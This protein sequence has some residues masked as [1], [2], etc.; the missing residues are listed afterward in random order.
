MTP[1]EEK[2]KLIASMKKSAGVTTS[3]TN[4]STEE[5]DE[6]GL[7]ITEKAKLVATV[8]SSDKF[9]SD[10]SLTTLPNGKIFL[11]GELPALP[12]S[13]PT[14]LISMNTGR[15]SSFA[16]KK[17]STDVINLPEVVGCATG[18]SFVLASTKKV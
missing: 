9:I 10:G 3:T 15:F 4:G 13:S 17:T 11:P 2:L 12:P 18:W 7:T 8:A 1:E 6:E 5:I 14:V 16:E